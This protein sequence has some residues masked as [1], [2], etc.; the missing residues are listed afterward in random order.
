[1]INLPVLVVT[2]T[3]FKIFVSSDSS[4]KPANTS[5][6]TSTEDFEVILLT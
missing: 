4:P 6:S 1:M 2:A 3:G 5:Q